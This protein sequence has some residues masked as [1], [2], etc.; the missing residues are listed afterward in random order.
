MK[1]FKKRLVNSF[2]RA[3]NQSKINSFEE[4]KQ[5]NLQNLSST[6]N[7]DQLNV[8]LT[9]SQE[10]STNVETG[11]KSVLD[12]YEEL[13]CNQVE[14]SLES[15]S[16]ADADALDVGR[17]IDLCQWEVVH[18]FMADMAVTTLK[19]AFE[20]PSE[21]TKSTP[22][23]TLLWKAPIEL[24]LF[25]LDLLPDE[26]YRASICMNKDA[27][28]NTGI[29]LFC[30]NCETFGEKE[31]LVLE[32]LVEGAPASLIATNH[33][34]ETPIHLLVTSK[35]CTKTEGATSKNGAG[36]AVAILL[37]ES[38]QQLSIQDSSGAT[39]LHVALA[40]NTFESIVNMLIETLS[41]S[42]KIAD[43]KGMLPLHYAAAFWQ[44]STAPIQA[45]LQGH[46]EDLIETTDDGDTPLHLLISNP[47]EGNENP[48]QNILALLGVL[49]GQAGEDGAIMIQNKEKLTPIHCCALFDTPSQIT[50]AI[51]HHP[52]AKRASLLP[53]TSRATALHL[54]VAQPS[55]GKS[56][57][58]VLTIGTTYA[59]KTED[60]LK[61]TPLHVAAQNPQ[62]TAKLIEVLFA[63]YPEASS[64][65]TQRGHLPLHL[66]AQ[67]KAKVEVIEA[68]LQLD[69]S[70]VK[71]LNKSNN[72]PLHD[73]AK[74]QAS[75]Q[76]VR[77][78]L[79]AYND[80]VYMGN[81]YGNFPLHCATA[82][83]A[84]T[85]VIKLLLEAWPNGASMQNRN[86]DTPLH[87]AAA[88]TSCEVTIDLLIKA[89]PSAVLLL[90]SNGQTPIDR[91]RANDAPSAI[92]RILEEAA[93][94]WK[95]KVSLELIAT[96]SSE[97][98][99]QSG[100]SSSEGRV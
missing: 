51:M 25:F 15:A 24:V 50:N 22:F 30:A 20:L 5:Q 80:A 14:T 47:R 13:E 49:T 92:I 65:V 73:A 57:D 53:N 99:V 37:K 27:D 78:L 69:S 28:G 11:I 59:A 77:L 23:Q 81:Q 42:C 66:A 31:L 97:A 82:Y 63:L 1:A 94:E 68:L 74:Y 98:D 12:S 72:T 26:E 62:C 56:I 48:D 89:G 35:A 91:A 10:N 71:M 95:D 44:S 93:T 52:L 7:C 87:Y 43:Y 90:N 60:R 75:A 29:H 33:E 85:E 16:S 67:S 83:Q 41:D 32:Q 76:V 19:Q 18:H 55:V 34:G 40:H 58:N 9:T 86:K 46:R 4:E 38:T 84:S 17:S 96:K 61:R 88:Y 100:N 79:D 8:P 36:K 70:S 21:D 6:G 2:A 64:M 39:P 3:E 45:M 54:A